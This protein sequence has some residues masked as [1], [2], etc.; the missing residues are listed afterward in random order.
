FTNSDKYWFHFF[1]SDNLPFS[2][3]PSGFRKD[4]VKSKKPIFKHFYK[5]KA[6][7]LEAH[8]K[9]FD[10]FINP[11]LAFGFGKETISDD[12][13]FRNTRGVE[14]RGQISNK[15]GFYSF[16]AENQVGFPTYIEQ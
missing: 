10:V 4:S 7:F 3:D 14:I 16:I 12:Y 1:R 15:L 5:T 2:K 6:N 13:T 9:D 11:V 8:T